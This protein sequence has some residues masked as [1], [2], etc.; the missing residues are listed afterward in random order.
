MLVVDASVAVLWF[1]PQEHAEAA[2]AILASK[3]RLVAPRLL[4]LET[5]SPLLHAV[6]RG[7][8]PATQARHILE[9][10]IPASVTFADEP[11]DELDAFEVARSH[12]GSAYDGLYVALARR[13]GAALVTNDRA[14]HRTAR[15]VGVE[16][17]FLGG[18][19]AP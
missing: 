3:V 14:M 6:R 11:S 13:L 9:V 1:V 5:A 17:R 4:R 18:E 16:A 8:M 12:G 10:L 19:L 2:S 7:E 15:E